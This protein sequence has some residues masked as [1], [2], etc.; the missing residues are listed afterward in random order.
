MSRLP[1]IWEDAFRLPERFGRM[2]GDMAGEALFGGSFGRADIYE[3][4]GQL[5]YEI[6]LPGLKREDISVR[7]ENDRL[8]IK[9]EVRKEE[10]VSDDDYLHMGRRY[11]RFQSA[12]PL[13][14]EVEEVDDVKARFEDG[15]LSVSLPLRKSIRGQV[16]DIE[17]E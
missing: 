8:M 1:Q 2:F 5:H 12:F 15:I 6:E 13:P 14:P 17:I 4:D 7:I 3:K 10:D 9:G 11:G 16:V